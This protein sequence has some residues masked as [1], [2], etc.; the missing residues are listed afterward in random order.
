MFNYILH[1]CSSSLH[2]LQ[3]S[4]IPVSSDDFIPVHRV[5]ARHSQGSPLPGSATP[6]VRHSQGSPLPGFTTPRVPHYIRYPNIAPPPAS[7]FS[8]ILTCLALHENE[9]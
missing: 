8:R 4:Y 2:Y 6:R 5:T 7:I 3:F 1:F 9:K